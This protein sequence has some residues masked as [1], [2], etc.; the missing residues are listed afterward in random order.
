MGKFKEVKVKVEFDLAVQDGWS[1]AEIMDSFKRR[2]DSWV[3]QYAS[4][5]NAS[6]TRPL[7]SVSSGIVDYEDDEQ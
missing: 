2:M 3:I 4:E 1:V 6:S 5:N 7:I